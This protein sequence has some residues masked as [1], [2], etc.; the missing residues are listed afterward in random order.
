MEGFK[1]LEKNVILELGMWIEKVLYK[2]EKEEREEKGKIKELKINL[3]K[4]KLLK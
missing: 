3:R 2:V 1:D 4:I